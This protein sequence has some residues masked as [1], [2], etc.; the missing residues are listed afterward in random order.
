VTH[1]AKFRDLDDT[2]S[3]IQ[4]P[5]NT[6]FKIQELNDISCQVQGP[7]D[8]SLFISFTPRGLPSPAETGRRPC[9]GTEARGRGVRDRIMAG[10]S[11]RLR[12]GADPRA[13][14]RC[15]GGNDSGA[16]WRCACDPRILA[17]R[18]SSTPAVRSLPNACLLARFT[19]ACAAL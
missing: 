8:F 17:P 13:C 2:Q 11:C 10:A 7:V 4:R 3:Q 12:P 16:R 18:G 9:S 1:K 6:L 14:S 5:K 19:D 15:A